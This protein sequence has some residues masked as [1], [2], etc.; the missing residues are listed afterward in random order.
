MKQSSPPQWLPTSKVKHLDITPV[1]WFPYHFDELVAVYNARTTLDR[2]GG[3]AGPVRFFL[4]Q[5]S[6]RRY[7]SFSSWKRKK[8]WETESGEYVEL[9]L[10]VN[11]R[12]VVWWEDFEE[13]MGP[14]NLPLEKVQRQGGFNWRRRRPQANEL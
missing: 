1:A 13:V 8:S 9:S 3:G 2:E 4:L 6:Y 12:G 14:L 7:A 11:E 10:R 5:M